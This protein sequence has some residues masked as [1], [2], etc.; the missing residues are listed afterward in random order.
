MLSYANLGGCM[1]ILIE[2]LLASYSV[3]FLLIVA[4]LM[5]ITFSYVVLN[6]FQEPNDCEN[7][8]QAGIICTVTGSASANAN[9]RNGDSVYEGGITSL[10]D[11]ATI[12]QSLPS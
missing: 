5:V 8:N 3:G 12:P 2:Y 6:F 7:Y 10:H 11:G 4:V 1:K 9:L